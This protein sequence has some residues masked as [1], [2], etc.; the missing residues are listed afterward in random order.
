MREQVKDC[1]FG[2]R[3]ESKKKKKGFDNLRKI[4]THT[5][6]HAQIICSESLPKVGGRKGVER[7]GRIILHFS[8]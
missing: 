1:L 4:N 8:R 5:H 7:R 6:A 2:E 3:E